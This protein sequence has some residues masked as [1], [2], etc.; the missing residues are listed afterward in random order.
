MQRFKFRNSRGDGFPFLK[1]KYS[2]IV[3]V[4]LHNTYKMGKKPA[5]DYD[6]RVGEKAR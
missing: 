6:L 4:R 5:G 2:V 3:P 1:N